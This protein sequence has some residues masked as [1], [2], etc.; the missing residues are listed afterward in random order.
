MIFFSFDLSIHQVSEAESAAALGEVAV[1]PEALEVLSKVFDFDESIYSI[2]GSISS[3]PIV[4]ASRSEHFFEIKYGVQLPS[5]L[6]KAA[7]AKELKEDVSMRCDSLEIPQ[8]QR[9]RQMIA[10]YVHHVVG[11]DELATELS[12][13]VNSSAHERHQAEAELRDVYTIFIMPLITAK[14]TGEE[15]KD[16]EL[17]LVLSKILLVVNREL[18]KYRGHL[19]QFIVDDKGTVN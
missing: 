10:L 9:L 18:S 4:I 6:D 14:L 11:K 16:R 13:R 2:T 8:L 3:K 5:F 17:F 1:S 7:T 12:L 15:K 19:R